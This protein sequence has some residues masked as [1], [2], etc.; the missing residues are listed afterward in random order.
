MEL[1]AGHRDIAA[2]IVS[3]LRDAYAADPDTVAERLRTVTGRKMP[4]WLRSQ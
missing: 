2:S 1:P 4:R 3:R